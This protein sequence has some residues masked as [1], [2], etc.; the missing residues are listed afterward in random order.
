MLPSHALISVI[1]V[2]NAR[3]VMCNI[4]EETNLRV[5]DPETLRRLPTSIINVN[6]TG[7]EPFM[8]K[9]LPDLVRAIHER[10]GARIVISSNGMIPNS[11]ERHI[12][13]IVAFKPEIG[14][15]ISIDGLSEMHAKIRGSEGA[16]EKAME[17]IE[18]LKRHGVKDLG[19]GF[20]ATGQN[21]EHIEKVYDLARRTGIQFSISVAQN[22]GIYFKTTSN[23]LNGN[24]A[25][26]R[27]QFERLVSSELRTWNP[28][29]WYRAFFEKRLHE[30]AETGVRPESCDA[31]SGFFYLDHDANVYPCNVLDRKVGNLR[32]KSFEEI[33]SSPE[34][35]R[36]R[37]EVAAC[38]QCW[39]VCT[40]SSSMQRRPLRPV[41]WI[42]SRKLRAH[43]GKPVLS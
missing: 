7:G 8:A 17:S 22:S 18:I 9:N 12:R 20:T 28:K 23:T 19:F 39:M 33:W 14:V 24:G 31:L 38:R 26:K 25:V 15:R 11:V 10:C 13:D 42:V 40:A 30:F 37:D 43:L 29:S 1:S 32:E 3:C 34:A 41:P 27:R 2:C 35:A 21:D 16:F 5:L 6:I 4:W 36:V